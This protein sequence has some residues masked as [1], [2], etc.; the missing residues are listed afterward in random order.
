[1]AAKDVRF[2]DDARSR[3]VRGVHFPSDITAG[4][5]L[6]EAIAVVLLETE[7]IQ[8]D[9]QHPFHRSPRAYAAG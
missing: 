7:A 4:F 3:M 8:R 6:G 1:M 5:V 9:P 2:A